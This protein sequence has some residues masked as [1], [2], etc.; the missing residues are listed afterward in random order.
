[1]NDRLLMEALD[2][3]GIGILR[4]DAQGLVAYANRSARVLL[5]LAEEP[6]GPRLDPQLLSKLLRPASLGHAV[7]ERDAD[8]LTEAFGALSAGGLV[9]LCM[10]RPIDGDEEARLRAAELEAIGRTTAKLAHD[11]NNLLGAIECCTDLLVHKI[12]RAVPGANPVEGQVRLIR[13]SIRKAT[14]MTAA[15]RGFVRPGPLHLAPGR[16]GEIVQSVKGLIAES[17][18]LPFE[19]ILNTAADPEVRLNEFQVGQML[20]GICLN[21]IEAMSAMQERVLVINLAEVVLEQPD[22]SG[23]APGR[24]AHLSVVDHGAGMNEQL[25]EQAFKPFSSTKPAGVGK[26]MGLA[27]AMSQEIMKRHGGAIVLNSVP[28]CGTAVHLYF[29]CAAPEPE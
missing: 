13:S 8:R 1:M 29:P 2:A 3:A 21:A 7:I 5:A 22:Q 18:L 14:E 26:G 20:T 16:L 10:Q 24:Y 19:I 17:E 9:V 6:A 27:L 28:D 4:A 15:M 25:R 11:F 23:L 12:G